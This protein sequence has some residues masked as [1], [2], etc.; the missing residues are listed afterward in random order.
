MPTYRHSEFFRQ[1]KTALISCSCTRIRALNQREL[2][3]SRWIQ[4]FTRFLQIQSASGF[5]LLACT[6]VSLW[7]ANSP[8]SASFAEI[9]QQVCPI[10]PKTVAH[11]AISRLTP[12]LPEIRVE[13]NPTRIGRIKCS[14]AIIT[15]IP[16]SESTIAARQRLQPSPR[17]RPR[18]LLDG[19]P[20]ARVG[21]SSRR[22]R[23][24]AKA[25]AA[26]RRTR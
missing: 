25:A 24:S 6:S 9:W 17:S 15:A 19:L 7:L 2:Q 13:M 12:S 23:Q 14:F 21:G 16:S 5:L 4:P 20:W 11:F 8:W 22:F 18:S 1:A 10:R 26:P 3:I